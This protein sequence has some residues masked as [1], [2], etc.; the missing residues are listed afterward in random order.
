MFSFESLFAFLGKGKCKERWGTAEGATITTKVNK[1]K[2]LA[3]GPVSA[4]K[5]WDL[6]SKTRDSQVGTD[7]FRLYL[8]NCRWKWFTLHLSIH[9]QI[10]GG[11]SVFWVPS[12]ILPSL[13]DA[14]YEAEDSARWDT[15]GAGRAGGRRTG[16]GVQGVTDQRT[17]DGVWR[18]E[19]SG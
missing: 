18:L 8:G 13:W 10:K 19:S 14:T 2:S 5:F 12:A 7:I 16:L 11:A 6:N 3:S 1:S 9:F 15:P 17:G 4:R